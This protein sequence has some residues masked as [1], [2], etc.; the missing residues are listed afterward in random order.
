MRKTEEGKSQL[1]NVGRQEAEGETDEYQGEYRL[2]EKQG[3]QKTAVLS[4][5][6]LCNVSTVCQFPEHLSPALPS[7]FPLSLPQTIPLFLSSLFST[8]YHASIETLA[9]QSAAKQRVK[10]MHTGGICSE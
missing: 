1:M 9:T 5:V 10:M 8:P 4:Q 3:E 6:L 7:L 2:E